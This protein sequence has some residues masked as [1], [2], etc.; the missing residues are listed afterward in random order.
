MNEM[1]DMRKEL[2]QALA[3]LE[4]AASE[5]V[6]IRHQLTFMYEQFRAMADV[7]L[8]QAEELRLLHEWEAE[9]LTGPYTGGVAWLRLRE[10]RSE[11]EALR[12]LR[13]D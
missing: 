10:F 4:K 9:V 13:G 3:D 8:G 12:R 1:R 11:Q 7:V 6:S 2:A 5:I